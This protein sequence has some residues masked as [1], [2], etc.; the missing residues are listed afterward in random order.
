VEDLAQRT[1]AE[2]GRVDIIINNAVAYYLAPF[3]EMPMRRWDVTLGVNLR[4]PILCSRAFLA[5]MLE[6]RGGRII[7]VSSSV[8]VRPWEAVK[9][10]CMPYYV[11][12]LALEGLTLALALELQPHNIAVNCLRIEKIIPSESWPLDALDLDVSRMEKP[13]AAAEAILWLATRDPSY[14]GHI[15][16]IDEARWAVDRGT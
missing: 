4:G 11:T 3:L 16:T 14:T 8:T 6:Q 10:G 13:E 7:N 1:L 12:K 15:V 2:F 5:Q 9:V